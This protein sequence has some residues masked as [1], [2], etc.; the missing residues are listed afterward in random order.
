MSLIPS[1]RDLF[2]IPSDITWLNCAYMSPLMKA[3]VAAGE[4]ANRSK[5]HPW[6]LSSQDFFDGSERARTL[7][8]RLILSSPP[9]A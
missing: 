8:G 4:E 3:V 6:T 7:A 9:Q 2:D 5:A 1:Q